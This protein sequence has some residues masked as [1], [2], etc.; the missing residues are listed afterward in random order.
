[1][2][3]RVIEVYNDSF[4]RCTMNPDFL[5]RFYGLF[6]DSSPQI[7]NFFKNTDL[8]KQVRIV[9]NSLYILTMASAGTREFLDEVERLGHTHG[10]DGLRID[11]DMYDLWLACLLQAV[12]EFDRFWTPEVEECWRKMLEPH[13]AALKLYS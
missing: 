4:E 8:K 1:M 5:M 11:A 9:K 10:R 7:K 12:K 3:E 6:L 13:I 2:N